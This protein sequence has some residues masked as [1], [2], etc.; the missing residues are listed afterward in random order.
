MVRSPWP[1]RRKRHL[2]GRPSPRVA[3]VCSINAPPLPVDV[4]MSR[5]HDRTAQLAPVRCSTAPGTTGQ[6]R[7]PTRKLT[8]AVVASCPASGFRHGGR[9]HPGGSAPR[10]RANL[11]AARVA[12]QAGPHERAARPRPPSAPAPPSVWGLNG[13]IRSLTPICPSGVTNCCQYDGGGKSVHWK[14]PGRV[15]RDSPDRLPV[16][17]SDR[18]APSFPVARAACASASVQAVRL[19]GADST[20]PMRASKILR[21]APLCAPRYCGGFRSTYR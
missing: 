15:E 14:L 16:S 4:V 20:S 12:R 8:R 7:D 9:G 18:R 11:D 13:M 2:R 19:F 10:R 6:S 3:Q 21:I 17:A 5:Y 1:T